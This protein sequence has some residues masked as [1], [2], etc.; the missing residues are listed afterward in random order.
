MA[1]VHAKGVLHQG[2]TRNQKFSLLL[3]LGVA[4]LPGSNECMVI[5]FLTLENFQLR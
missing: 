1:I 2:I 3:N 4:G 5:I